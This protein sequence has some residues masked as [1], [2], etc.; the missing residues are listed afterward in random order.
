MKKIRWSVHT[1]LVLL[2]FGPALLGADLS[3]YRGFQFGMSLSA[4]VKH[5]GM[6]SSEATT[7]I[8][9]PALIQQLNWRPSR[10]SGTSGEKDPVD[11]VEF[12]FLDAQLFR[13]VVDYDSH[14][15]AGLTADDLIDGIAA[16]YGVAVRP[17]GTILLTS[18]FSDEAT[19]VLARWEDADYS[20][21]LV[22]RPYSTSLKLVMLSKVVSA[23][24]GAAIS[25]GIRLDKE[26]APALLKLEEEKAKTELDR[27]RLVNK[28]RFRP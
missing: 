14:K 22:Q 2:A 8:K 27:N 10:Y 11:Q 5:S 26:E 17:G 25:E 28:A 21:N 12:R 7:V 1:L 15:V 23:R 18:Q 3:T 20:F 16:Q 13:I 4:A 9:R 6:D 19:H 24:A